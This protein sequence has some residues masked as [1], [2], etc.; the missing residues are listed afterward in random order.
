MWV[1]KNINIF[2][3]ICKKLC[4]VLWDMFSGKNL[5]FG[6]IYSFI[7]ILSSS[8]VSKLYF[9]INL[10]LPCPG[11]TSLAIALMTT[12]ISDLLTEV[13][14]VCGG[15]NLISPCATLEKS[16]KDICSLFLFIFTLL[17]PSNLS[18]FLGSFKSLVFICSISTVVTLKNFKFLEVSSVYSFHQSGRT[19]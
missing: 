1:V 15:S 14:C 5:P 17:L 7:S 13:A 16:F 19:W 3:N 9:E 2:D 6:T 8:Q 4:F 10:L 18:H 11:H 12:R